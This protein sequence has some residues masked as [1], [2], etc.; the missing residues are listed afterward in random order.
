VGADLRHD[1]IF[2]IALHNTDDRVHLRTVRNDAVA[3]TSLGAYVENEMKWTRKV[4]TTIGLRADA[5]RFD[6]DSRLDANAGTET[7]V[8]ASPKFTLVL[9]PWRNT[10]YYLNFGFGYHSNDARGTTIAVDPMTREPVSPVDPLVQSRGAEVGAR[11]AVLPGLQSTASLWG[12]RLDSELVF[13]GDAGGTEA[14]GASEHYGVEWTNYYRPTEWLAL[15]LDVAL[16]ESHFTEAPSGN[17]E[18]PNSIGRMITGGVSVGRTTGWHGGLRVRHF[19][20]RPL[21][22][23]ARVESQATTLVNVKVGYRFRNLELDVDILNVLDSNGSDI[24]YFF[25]SRLQGESSGGVADVH[26]HPVLPRTARLSA[27]WHF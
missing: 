4:R 22:T 12:M 25:N 9:G 10:E 20:P 13:V 6:V 5:F 1:Q 8:I 23:D 15:N 21:T 11:T 19:G 17:D 14:K 26:F 24:S 16:T 18:I 7:D 2:E 27:T 3:E